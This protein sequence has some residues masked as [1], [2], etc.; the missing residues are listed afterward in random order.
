MSHNGGVNGSRMYRADLKVLHLA[1]GSIAGFRRMEPF[2]AVVPRIGLYHIGKSPCSDVRANTYRQ[3]DHCD[4]QFHDAIRSVNGNLVVS[5]TQHLY[6]R[7]Y[8]Y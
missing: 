1:V 7:L 2:G 8:A 5:S 3:E 4:T 6:W